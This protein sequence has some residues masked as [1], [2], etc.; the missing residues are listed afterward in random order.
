MSIPPNINTWVQELGGVGRNGQTATATILYSESD[1]Q[2]VLGWLCDHL[3]N[4]VI[5]DTILS[6]YDASWK[7][8]Y[9][10]LAE[11]CIHKAL[12]K[13]YKKLQ[14][15]AESC[16]GVCDGPERD[17]I[18]C[19]KEARSWYML[20]KLWDLR[21]NVKSQSFSEDPTAHG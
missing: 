16:C 20:Y 18:P 19:T 17:F 21:E 3:R 7:L 12:L 10:K 4:R 11:K 9:C 13:Y 5:R 2:N 15:G 8:V 6:E 1:V 14:V